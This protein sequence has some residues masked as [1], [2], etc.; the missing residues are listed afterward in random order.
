MKCYCKRILIGECKYCRRK[1]KE[2][3]ADEQTK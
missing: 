2:E 1:A 3:K